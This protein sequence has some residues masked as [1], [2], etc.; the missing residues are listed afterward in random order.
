MAKWSVI[1]GITV[2]VVSTVV[3][4]F[5]FGSGVLSWLGSAI[6]LLSIP[7]S[8]TGF[9]MG[10]Y[11]AIRSSVRRSVPIMGAIMNLL[12]LGGYVSY[13]WMSALRSI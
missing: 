5:L 10:V 9:L 13:Q 7:V 2:P 1:L 6:I 4:P 3:V 12:F 11:A 8:L